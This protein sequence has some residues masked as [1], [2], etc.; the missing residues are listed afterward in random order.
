MFGIIGVELILIFIEF[1]NLIYENDFRKNFSHVKFSTLK[2][3]V[4]YAQNWVLQ[5]DH[6][7]SRQQFNSHNNLTMK[8]VIESFKPILHENMRT[9]QSGVSIFRDEQIMTQIK[10]FR[11]WFS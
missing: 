4:I 8:I 11:H 9:T 3:K 2:E 10:A 6:V 5:V 7:D 1:F